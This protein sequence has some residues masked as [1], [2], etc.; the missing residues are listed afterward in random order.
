[1]EKHKLFLDELDKE[2]EQTNSEL[3]EEINNKIQAYA[4]RYNII[5][6]NVFESSYNRY[7]IYKINK[8]RVWYLSINI[9]IYSMPLREMIKNL[10][11]LVLIGKLTPEQLTMLNLIIG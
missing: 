5:P 9:K 2:L 11:D 4:I 6:G 1:M 7:T 10:D 8:D 3:R